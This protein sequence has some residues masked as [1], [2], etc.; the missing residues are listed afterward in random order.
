[1]LVSPARREFLFGLG[2]T[3]GTVALTTLL[4]TRRGPAAGPLSPRSP[5]HKARARACIFLFME[6]G[7]SHIDTFDPKPKLQGL[8][9][10]EFVR[11]E[12]LAS[13]MAQGKRYYVQ[14]P[15][16]FRKVGQAGIDLCAPF[17]HLAGV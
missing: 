9:L 1:M 10:N 13:A 8:H 6:G 16:E 15:F 11:R 4:A 14:S 2:A 7:P 17:E 12:A 3:L 5:H